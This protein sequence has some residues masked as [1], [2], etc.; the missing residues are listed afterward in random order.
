[1]APKSGDSRLQLVFALPI[2]FPLA[3]HRMGKRCIGDN[4]VLLAIADASMIFSPYYL[5]GIGS[6]MGAFQSMKWPT[7]TSPCESGY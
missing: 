4:Q 1:M 2:A 5:A 6:E 3:R 7:S